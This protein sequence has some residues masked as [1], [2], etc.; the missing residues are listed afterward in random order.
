MKWSLIFKALAIIGIVS[1]WSTKALA[2]GKVTTEEA[3]DLG[4]KVATALGIKEIELPTS[5]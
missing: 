5:Q 4:V 1:E 3:A 2:D